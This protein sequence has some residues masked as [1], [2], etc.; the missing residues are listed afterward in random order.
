[1]TVL[2]TSRQMGEIEDVPTLWLGLAGFTAAERRFLADQ[3]Q[4]QV[5]PV[6]WGL[7]VFPDADAWLISGERTQL[8]ESHGV[9]IA[10]GEPTPASRSPQSC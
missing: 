6:R 7:S 1:M 3:A 10:P 2:Q 5:A 4:Q 9:R 8:L